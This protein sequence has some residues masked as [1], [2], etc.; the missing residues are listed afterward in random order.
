MRVCFVLV[1][2]LSLLFCHV[3][4]K[5]TKKA[6][7]VKAATTKATTT[8]ATTTVTVKTTTTPPKPS[9]ASLIAKIVVAKLFKFHTQK[10]IEALIENA[11]EEACNLTSANTIKLNLASAVVTNCTKKQL[12]T[13]KTDLGGMLEKF[14]DRNMRLVMRS[15]FDTVFSPF[16]DPMVNFATVYSMESNCTDS[17]LETLSE[18]VTDD[19]TQAAI[20]AGLKKLSNYECVTLVEGFNAYIPFDSQG[21]SSISC[22]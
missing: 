7:T 18:L 19:A 14:G 13:M 3:C 12:E 21:F 1:I 17:T 9:E 15:F 5:T 10:V 6:T 16:I 4:G 8:K 11:V 20:E 2:L 22:V